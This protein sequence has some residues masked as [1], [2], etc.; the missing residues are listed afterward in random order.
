[1]A[2]LHHP[3]RAAL[4]E[5]ARGRFPPADGALLVLPSPPG[6]SDA[7]VA[8]TAHHVVAA[9]VPEVAVRERLSGEDLGAPMGARFLAWL[10]DRIGS[11]PG[12]LDVVLAAPGTGMSGDVLRPAGRVAHDRVARAERYRDDVRVL[13]DAE[14]RGV[15]IMGLGLAGR[16]ELSIEL[17]AGARDRGLGRRLIEAA[18][19]LV[20]PDEV[21]FAQVAPG[22]AASLR[23]FLA[24]GFR[25]IGAEVLF[26]RGRGGA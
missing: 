25:P 22:N 4:E 23:A 6:R 9:P 11:E 15:V 7:V 18:R 8:F 19:G 24:A 1:M 16:L 14:R 12:S 20:T 17:E 26:P 10:A 5:A 3:L 13:T 21:V 2:P